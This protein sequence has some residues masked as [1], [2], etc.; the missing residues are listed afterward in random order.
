MS[1]Q[2]KKVNFAVSRRRYMKLDSKKARGLFLDP[3]CVT[4]GLDR[5][6]AIKQLCKHL[7]ETEQEVSIAW[8]ERK[9]ALSLRG[10][11]LGGYL[12]WN[13]LSKV[14]KDTF[15]SLPRVAFSRFKT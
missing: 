8:F 10:C 1:N 15:E 14:G 2:E 13:G 11:F 3:F 12:I 6:H 4:T 9:Q 5:K 7:S